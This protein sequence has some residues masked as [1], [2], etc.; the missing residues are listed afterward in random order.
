VASGGAGA[1]ISDAGNWIFGRP[2]TRRPNKPSS[3]ISPR[4]NDTGYIEGENVVVLYRY[5]ENRVDRLPALAAELARRPVAVLVA[6]GGPNVMFAAKQA[7]TTVPIVFLS[8][9]DPV[10]L[11]LVSSLA[12]P[13]GNMTGINFFNRE[14]AGKQLEFLRE[15]VP[16]ASRIAVLVNPADATV[17][18][19]T[20]RAVEAAAAV[21][22][23][24]VQVIQA[25]SSLSSSRPLHRAYS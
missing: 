16:S 10:G 21:K 11:G 25:S 8:G 6:S 20:V 22:G 5:A 17:M 24:Q 4:L 7:T 9:E 18:E 1:A 23:L 2:A 3:R 15:L 13:G 12:H 14:L 19:T